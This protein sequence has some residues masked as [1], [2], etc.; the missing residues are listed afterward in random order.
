MSSPSSPSASA[1]SKLTSSA[2]ASASS[3]LTTATSAPATSTL[4]SASSASASSKLTTATSASASSKLTTATPT[5]KRTVSSTSLDSASSQD[6]AQHVV[7]KR[8]CLGELSDEASSSSDNDS[9]ESDPEGDDD[10]QE[11]EEQEEEEQEDPV[12]EMMAPNKWDALCG[13]HCKK[14]IEW[15]KEMGDLV[16]V[17]GTLLEEEY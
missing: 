13:F 5:I 7:H 16:E 3:K 6:P 11:E 15:K 4:T 8:I 17:F 14:T 10:H 1:T 12:W 2:S 9:G